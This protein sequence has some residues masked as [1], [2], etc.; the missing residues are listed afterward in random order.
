MSTNRQSTFLPFSLS[1]VFVLTLIL[2]LTLPFTAT[3]QTED[4]EPSGTTE[5]TGED[6]REIELEPDTLLAE[7]LGGSMAEELLSAKLAGLDTKVHVFELVV[8]RPEAWLIGA[9]G[10]AGL[11]LFLLNDAEKL[12]AARGQGETARGHHVV[13]TL[14]PGRYVVRIEG[15]LARYGFFAVPL[16]GE[17]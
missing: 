14:A 10:E 16:G 15:R 8:E 3:A 17:L 11:E 6:P 4:G 1:L 5:G 12:L 9:S 7:S 2:A 13:K